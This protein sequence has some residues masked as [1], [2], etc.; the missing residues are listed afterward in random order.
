MVAAEVVAVRDAV[1][2]NAA[3]RDAVEVAEAVTVIRDAMVEDT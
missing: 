3:V 1:V 2:V